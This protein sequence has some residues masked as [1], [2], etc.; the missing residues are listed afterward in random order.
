MLTVP[1]T[2]SPSFIDVVIVGGGAAGLSA[3]SALGRVRR[4]AI[5]IDSGVYRKDNLPLQPYSRYRLRTFR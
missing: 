5:L 1:E 4:S 3:A 2:S